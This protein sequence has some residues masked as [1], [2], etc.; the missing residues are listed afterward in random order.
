VGLC[1]LAGRASQPKLP[2]AAVAMRP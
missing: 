1:A 2:L